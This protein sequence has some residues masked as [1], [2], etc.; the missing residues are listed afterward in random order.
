[1]LRDYLCGYGLAILLAAL[2]A[3]PLA[4]DDAAARHFAERVQPLLASRCVSCHGPD[5]QEGK[6]RLDT[7]GAALKGG[8]HGPAF[9]PGKP[10]ESLLIKSVRHEVP[11][12]EQA[13]P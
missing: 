6:L 9:V 11:K 5:E 3:S 13:M 2:A 4:A 10:A 12:P 8:T 7:R 1:M